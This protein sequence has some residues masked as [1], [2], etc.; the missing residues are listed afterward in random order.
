MSTVKIE[1][2]DWLFNAGVVGIK[3]VL[4]NLSTLDMQVV[5]TYNYIEFDET[6]LKGFEEKYFETLIKTNKNSISINKIIS[7]KNLVDLLPNE[8]ESVKKLND[9]IYYIK[10]KAN[11]KSYKAGYLLLDNGSEID[12]L[13]SK[14]TKV[15]ITKKQSFEEIENNYFTQ[16]RNIKNICDFFEKEN[17]KRIIAAKNVMYEIIQPFWTNVSILLNAN[18]KK[19]MYKMFKKDFVDTAINYI[20]SDKTKYKYNCF[21]CDNKIS[22]LSKP[23]AFDLTWIVKTG[24]DM[25]RKSSHFWNM[26]ADAYICPICNLV[27]SCIPL[28]FTILKGKGIFINNNTSIKALNT[29][30]ITKVIDEDER[31]EEIEKRS[32]F[33]IVNA[34]ENYDIENRINEFENIQVIKFDSK[35]IARPYSF[36]ILSRR[37]IWILYHN[38]KRLDILSKIIVKVTDKYYINLYSEVVDR[39]YNGKNLYDLIY[40]LLKMNLSKKFNGVYFINSILE[41]NNWIIG[42]NEMNSEETKKFKEYGIALRKKYIEINSESKLSG[43]TYRLLNALKTKD[44]S[45]FMDTLINAYM[46]SGKE[47][48]IEFTKGLINSD[49]LQAI[50]Y[51]FLIGLQGEENSKKKEGEVNE[52]E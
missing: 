7:Y 35:N 40:K 33:Q 2:K 51:A 17:V 34:M 45:K 29:T 46:Y 50:G 14:L 1:L 6:L 42:G 43:I 4:D 28:G 11:S 31:F 41:I 15:K 16:I 30:N 37:L 38:R 25:S 32:Y 21:I 13:I 10:E 44:N 8:K 23:Y 3:K 27:Y 24:V 36:N 22:K 26:K 12:S 52:N 49:I 48:P 18:N 39:L 19:D 9:I 5:E 20:D 47:I